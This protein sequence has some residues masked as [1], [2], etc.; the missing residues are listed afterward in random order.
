[1]GLQRIGHTEW[2]SLHFTYYLDLAISY[3]WVSF[4]SFYGDPLPLLCNGCIYYTGWTY[5]DL[6]LNSSYLIFFT[7]YF[8]IDYCWY[9]RNLLIWPAYSYT[10]P[11]YSYPSVDL[12]VFSFDCLKFYI[13]VI[14]RSW[15]LCHFLFS[16]SLPISS[17]CPILG[18][19]LQKRDKYHWVVTIPII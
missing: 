2:L 19:D 4:I 18:W 17:C 12:I 15:H 3:Y 14:K 9:V 11:P 7:L 5:A 1:M 10:W 6:F 8:I 13:T 16:I